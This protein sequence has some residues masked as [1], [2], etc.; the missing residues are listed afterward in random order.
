[1]SRYD[2]LAHLCRSL[3]LE[4]TAIVSMFT[5]YCDDSGT[6]KGSRAAVVAGYIAQV[7]E[8][9]RLSKDWT[10]VLKDFRVRQIHRADLEA[11]HGEFKKEKGWD[12]TRRT[13]LLQRLNP[14]IKDR[15][16]VAMAAA[17]IK[18]DF[19]EVM[20]Q[21]LKIKFGGVYGWCAHELIVHA[22]LWADARN[23]RKPINWVFEAG[24]RGYGQVQEMFRSCYAD[25]RFRESYRIG[26]CSFDSKRLVPLQVADLLAYEIFKQ[27][28][29]RVID[30]GQ[31]YDIRASVRGLLRPTDDRFLK[32]WGKERLLEWLDDWR[33]RTAARN[34]A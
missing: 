21:E 11:F 31:K 10:K 26:S 16:K 20:P 23:H 9:E 2:A 32:Y 25:K 34:S 5:A 18:E 22:R 27:M 4:D 8:W 19:E 14:I 28:E 12:A 33:Q 15:T 7:V 30:K 24:T 17:V 29:N 3:F 6:H 1:M 13:E